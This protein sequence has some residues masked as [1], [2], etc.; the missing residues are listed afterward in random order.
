MLS[1]I[2]NKDGDVVYIHADKVGLEQLAKSVERLQKH[3]RDDECEHDH[4]FSASWA[5]NEL[6]ETML[7][8]E[9]HEGGHQVHHVK[10]Y[11]W[12]DEWKN[13]HRLE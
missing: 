3:L 2:S 5:G 9:R 1:V 8:E 7:D 4:F 6:T 13:K 11:A 12:T 10:L